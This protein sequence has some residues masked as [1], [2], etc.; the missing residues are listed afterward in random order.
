MCILEGYYGYF[1]NYWTLDLAK[2][3]YFWRIDFCRA[4]L[5]SVGLGLCK[6]SIIL[7]YQRVFEGSRLRQVLIATH[8][9]NILLVLSYVLSAFLVSRPLSC[10]WELN[11]S[12]DCKYNDV[13][14]G[15]GAYSAVNAVFDVWL[16]VIPAVV[17]G[18]LQMK[19]ESKV[20]V[21]AVFATG[22]V[23]S[24][25]AV[26]RF[27]LYRLRRNL[28]M[29]CLSTCSLFFSSFVVTL[30]VLLQILSLSQVPP[31]KS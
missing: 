26:M 27:V 3:P 24:L 2:L 7:L 28:G 17:V 1:I 22:I 19:R 21:T 18:R 12:A 16:V 15:S 30:I 11:Q 8:T 4:I 29:L 20:S 25:V 31:P 9:F 6:M 10:N 23:T 14:D 13:W 5:Y